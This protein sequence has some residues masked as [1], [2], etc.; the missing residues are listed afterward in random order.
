M[1]IRGLN[2]SDQIRVTNPHCFP[3]ATIVLLPTVNWVNTYPLPSQADRDIAK[4]AA[5]PVT[6]L[7]CIL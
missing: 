3:V 4:Y 1:Q 2:F 5:H 7:A 6:M